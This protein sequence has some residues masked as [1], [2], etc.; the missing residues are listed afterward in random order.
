MLPKIN[1]CAKKIILITGF[2]RSG[3][4]LLCPIISSLKD[5]EQFFF[6]TISEN[7]SVLH[8]MKSINFNTAD[9][10]I[11]R[12]INENV[13]DKLLGRNLN[14]KKN[15]FTSLNN[16]KNKNIYIKRMRSTKKGNFEKSKEFKNNL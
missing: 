5:C 9:Y 6:S 10:M 12:T 15:D 7:I 14:N 8:Y 2:T 1:I 13:Q 4:T 3:K 11:K 16:Y